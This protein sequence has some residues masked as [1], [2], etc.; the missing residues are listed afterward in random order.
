MP[1]LISD[2]D[3]RDL[4]ETF[5]SRFVSV[6]NQRE[7]RAMLTDCFAAHTLQLTREDVRIVRSFVDTSYK[8][9][10]NMLETIYGPLGHSDTVEVAA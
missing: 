7:A 1:H 8:Q 2:A 10:W 5:V 3:A 4:I 9:A 6:Q